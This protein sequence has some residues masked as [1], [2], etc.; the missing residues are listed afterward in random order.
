M[1]APQ[2]YLSPGHSA[3]WGSFAPNH[4]EGC[5]WNFCLLGDQ[6]KGEEGEWKR[7]M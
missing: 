5:I 7:G 6:N 3:P 1:E 4:P 2:R